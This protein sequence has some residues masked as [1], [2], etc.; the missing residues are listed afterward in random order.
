MQN[1]ANRTGKPIR[2]PEREKI[3]ET[4]KKYGMEF[5]P[6]TEVLSVCA[7]L[8]VHFLNEND[9][10]NALQAL[11]MTYNLTRDE[12]IKEIILKYDPKAER[13]VPD[14]KPVGEEGKPNITQTINE[15]K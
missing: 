11:K 1:I 2:H 15:D 13:L 6:N 8:S 9:I 4:M 12:K 5:G 7:Q 10:P 14:Q 3:V